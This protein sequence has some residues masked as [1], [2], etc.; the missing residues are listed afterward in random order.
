MTDDLEALF[1]EV[2]AQRA[3][4]NAPAQMEQ[5]VDA[6]PVPDDGK[7]ASDIAYDSQNMQDKP[8]YERLGGIVRLLHDSLR[9]LGYDRSLSDAATQIND[10]QGRLEHIAALTEQAANR[11]LNTIDAGIPEQ[12]AVLKSAQEMDSR[13][14]RLF[15]G[16]MSI[17]EFRLLA[18]DSKEFALQVASAT[19]TEKARLLDIMMAQDFQDITGQL[20]KKIVAVTQKV[21]NELAQLLLDNAPAEVAQTL[22]E[23]PE[24]LMQGPSTNALGQDDVDSLL[25]GLGF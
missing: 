9:E 16:K 20:I 22:K 17:E 1:E 10:A 12:E 8:M 11:V 7:L 19:E 14:S 18:T 21:E 24:S 4:A 6:A 13:W 2:S 5:T 3:Q 15:E 25:E 23:S